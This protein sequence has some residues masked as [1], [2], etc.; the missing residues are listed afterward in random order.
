MRL[1]R[2]LADALWPRGLQC[3]CCERCTDG[4]LLCPE[5]AA[6][7]QRL[8]LPMENGPVQSVWVYSGCASRLVVGLKD[9]CIADCAKVLAEGMAEVVRDMQLPS[10]TVLTW[11]TMPK[12]RLRERGIDHG[13]MLCEEIAA[14]TGMKARKLL[15]RTRDGHTQRGLSKVQ[16]WRN[17]EGRFGCKEALSGAVLLIDDVLTT[18]ATVQTCSDVLKRGG[19]QE[20]FVIT[21]TRVK[22][23]DIND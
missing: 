12:A 2:V 13:R 8:R 5:C 15:V 7:L 17:L 19:A 18:G 20:V 11:A 16:R 22:K 4:E 23:F 1:L 3:L 14:R 9:N 21:A 6:Q 10:D